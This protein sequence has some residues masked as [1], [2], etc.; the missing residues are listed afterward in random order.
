MPDKIVYLTINQGTYG[1]CKRQFLP[2]ETHLIELYNKLFNASHVSL[3][4]ENNTS[5]EK[6]VYP[7]LDYTQ[8]LIKTTLSLPSS[9]QVCLWFHHSQLSLFCPFL[10]SSK[11]DHTNFPDLLLVTEVR[12]YERTSFSLLNDRSQLAIDAV[13]V[14]IIS[15]AFRRKSW[16]QGAIFV[17]CT[18]WN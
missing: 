4:L 18:T 11:L 16:L 2:N 13:I 6:L 3:V 9:K 14:S 8:M 7:A 17:N 10:Y 1:H 5:I 12:S 15:K